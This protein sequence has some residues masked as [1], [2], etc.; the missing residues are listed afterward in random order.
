[1]NTRI[2]AVGLIATALLS[3]TACSSSSD[4]DTKPS[5]PAYKVVHRDT[6]GNQRKITVEVTSETRLRAVFDDVI[7]DADGNAGYFVE[8]NCST[9]GTSSV[10][11][12]LA[13]GQYAAGNIGAATTGLKDGE[14]KFEPVA[15]RSCPAKS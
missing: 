2:T 14:S 7:K 10:D 12:R 4:D 9:G 13:N 11:N 15:G 1:M 8:I 5:A 6:S 3:L